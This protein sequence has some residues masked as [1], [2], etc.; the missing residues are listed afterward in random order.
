MRFVRFVRLL[1]PT[2]TEQIKFAVS[3]TQ[4][5]V[6]FVAVLLSLF[7][8]LLPC[9]AKI[10]LY[11]SWAIGDD[12]IV[13]QR[14]GIVVVVWC[15]TKNSSSNLPEQLRC[16]MEEMASVRITAIH[17]CSPDTPLHRLR[18]TVTT[19][20]CGDEQRSNFRFHLGVAVD[21]HYALHGY[22]IPSSEIP[23][24][25]TGRIKTR[26]FVQWTRI[27]R[28]IESPSNDSEDIIVECPQLNDALFRGGKS[29]TNFAGNKMLRKMVENYAKSFSH[30]TRQPR[31]RRLLA[32]M[33]FEE[34]DLVTAGGTKKIGRYLAWDLTSRWWTVLTD[35][36]QIYHKIEYLVREITRE[37]NRSETIRLLS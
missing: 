30:K 4:K 24:T 19:A 2:K 14:K 18:R 8:S 3:I 17:W 36:E 31:G 10:I 29:Y 9:Q 7:S 35:R 26:P 37:L 34:C 22:G 20:R 21:L 12:D 11:L 25:Y 15:D 16:T 6:L 33:I 23:V 13:T 27:R 5:S 32:L 28:A 1:A